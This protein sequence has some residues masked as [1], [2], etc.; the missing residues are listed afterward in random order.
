MSIQF[1]T[2]KVGSIFCAIDILYVREITKNPQITPV[3]LVP[4]SIRGL[5]NL[6]GQI[7]TVLDLGV[8]INQ[9]PVTSSQPFCILLKTSLELSKTHGTIIDSTIKLNE[10]MGILVDEISDLITINISELEDV[11]ASFL[12]MK[13]DFISKI[14]KTNEQIYFILDPYLIVREE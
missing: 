14:F 9:N 3:C 11:P 7:V 8:K 2:F 10:S 6:R 4:K 1:T 12:E 13:K 5:Q